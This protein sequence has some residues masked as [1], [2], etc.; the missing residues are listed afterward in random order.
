[1]E[2]ENNRISAKESRQYRNNVFVDLFYEDE[3]ADENDIA[4]YNA[5]HEEKLPEGT[6]IRRFRVDDVLYMNFRNDV[7]FGVGERVIVFG[8]HQSTINRN[9]PLRSLMYIGRAY[10][11]LVPVRNRYRR[12]IVKIPAP[13]FYTFYN[14]K[15]SSPDEFVLK[16]SDAFM[17][18]LAEPPLELQ[19]KIINISN[20]QNH[21]IL[22][23]CKIL[24]EYAQFI[25]CVEQHKATGEPD[26]AERAIKE[27]MKKNILRDYLLRKGSEVINM[28]IA[29]YDYA[30]DIE[31][32][33]EE[34]LEE[35]LKE[36]LKKGESKGRSRVNYL[37]QLLAK[38][39]RMEDII[40]ATNDEDYQL[41]LFKEFGI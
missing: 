4:L 22:Q 7:S 41:K 1:M 13:E 40:R 20:K 23:N 34:A 25:E 26:A 29:E 10:E 9:I 21:K 6:A 16:L 2:I 37:N 28:L 27:C 8:E 31:V 36:G 14:G 19:V 5:L 11:Q 39:N 32:Q 18:K 3:T 33:R 12:T 24:K 30:T 15:Q 17:E 35:G 38:Q